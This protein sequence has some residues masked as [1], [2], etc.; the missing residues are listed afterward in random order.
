MDQ[1]LKNYSS[2]MQVRLAFSVATKLAES[3][4][5]LI[6]EVL[7][8]GDADFQ[9]KCF[10][11]F[12]QLKKDKKTVVFVSHDM[13]AIKEFCDR[14]ALIESS[15][16]VAMG[17]TSE[18]TEKYKELFLADDGKEKGLNA[19]NTKKR[20]GTGAVKLKNIGV[21][22]GSFSDK[23]EFI[24]LTVEIEG[25]SENHDLMTGFAVKDAQGL[26]INGS[27]TWDEK[28][29]LPELKSGEMCEVVWK[30][31]NIYEDGL[32]TIDV[33]S[34]GRDNEVYDKLD[35]AISF[36][37]KRLNRSGCLVTFSVDATVKRKK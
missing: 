3:D 14:A 23:D 11:Y 35:D 21:N 28:K 2:G 7:A 37:V 36:R 16:L 27:H 32:H 34:Y 12:R 8:V 22:K 24:N 13:G 10:D 25:V 19:L 1:K 5:L 17:H 4:I 20:S 9:R 15:K 26:F 33:Y 6:D 18:I 31:P 30:L 29:D